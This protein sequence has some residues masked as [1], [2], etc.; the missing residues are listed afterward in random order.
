MFAT[1]PCGQW[2]RDLGYRDLHVRI[3]CPACARVLSARC[4]D[5]EHGGRWY[6]DWT[7]AEDDE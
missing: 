1:C 6:E 5:Y 4:E 7:F 3:V 2:W